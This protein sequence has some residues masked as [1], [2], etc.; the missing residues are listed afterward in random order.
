MALQSSG[1][2]SLANV[3]TEFG[4]SAPTS[5]SEYYGVDTGVPASG[6]IALSDFYGTSALEYSLLVGS[7]TIFTD[8]NVITF[9]TVKSHAPNAILGANP[10]GIQYFGASNDGAGNYYLVVYGDHEDYLQETAESFYWFSEVAY[11]NP[12]LINTSPGL[13][14]DPWTYYPLSGLTATQQ[15][16]A[17]DAYQGL[18]F[19]G[20]YLTFD[21]G[22]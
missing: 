6:T 2:I 4:G 1:A 5:I 22:G 18:N 9:G 16:S 15:S 3:Q 17:S 12:T 19:Y 14:G 10:E 7:G 11:R 13:G 8:T 20:E 21:M